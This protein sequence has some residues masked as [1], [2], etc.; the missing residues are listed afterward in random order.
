V[1]KS[2]FIGCSHTMGYRHYDLDTPSTVW[3]DNNYAEVYSQ[4][5]DKEVIIMASAGAGNRA[6]PNFLAHALK[7]H[8]DIDEVF[9]QSTYWGRF[10]FAINPTLN[11]KEILP[12]DFFIEKDHADWNVIRYSLGLL[13]KEK[14][15]EQYLKANP[16]D[17][18]NFKY[19]L[20]T[21]PTRQPDI[22]S[23]VYLY[24]QMWHY[25]QTHLAQQDYMKDITF[26]D[27][28]CKAHNLPMY[29]WN[30][31]NRCFIP[32]NVDGFYTDLTQTKFAS[33][34]AITYLQDLT[35]KNLE[36]EKVDTEHYNRYVHELIAK[37]YIPYI[38][39][40]T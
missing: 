40:R 39:E 29:V 15:L 17:Y 35:T 5:N 9:I 16:E 20:D 8:N 1:G 37:E 3:Q 18:S 38:K 11:E 30:I 21:S 32:D 36:E 14:Y 12:L 25:N 22:K 31:N 27:M 6:Y 24:I 28:L 33:I 10:P 13:Q 26:C 23:T 19:M 7:E 34:D 4:I 2:L